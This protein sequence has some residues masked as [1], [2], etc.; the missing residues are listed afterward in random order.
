MRG[1]AVMESF[2]VW[3][4]RG[5]TAGMRVRVRGC[6]GEGGGTALRGWQLGVRP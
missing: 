1:E 3:G 4:E 6:V 5:G 2:R